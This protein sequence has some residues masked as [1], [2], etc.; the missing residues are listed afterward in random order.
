MGAMFIGQQ[1]LQNVLG[2]STL[3]AGAAILPAALVHGPRRAALGQ[4]RRG[5]R[6]AVHAAARLRVRAAR[7]PRRCCCCGTR[8]SPTGWSGSA[9]RFVGIGVGFAGTPASHS[10]TGLGAGQRARDGVGHGRPPARPR[11]RD[12]AVDLRRA[13]HR[14][15]TPRRSRR[16][17]AASPDA[18][19][20]RPASRAQLTKSYASAEDVAAAVPA[21]RDRRSS[22]GGQGVVPR[23]RRVAYLAGIVAVLIGAALVFFVFPRRTRSAPAREVP[24]R[25]HDSRGRQPAPAGSTP[26]PSPA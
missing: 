10:L 20:S 6:R 8:A 11:R 24:R 23:R 2:Y 15:A 19:T 9:T 26:V 3:E 12:H 18:A 17:I 22:A 13:A 14:R 21:V 1:Y 5:A 25:G 4:A 16:A 7:L